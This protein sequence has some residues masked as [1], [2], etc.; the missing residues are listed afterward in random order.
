MNNQTLW[1]TTRGAGM[2][3]LILLSAVLALGV[4]AQSRFGTRSWPRFLTPAFHRNLSM[5]A[6]LF[7]LLHIVTAVTDPFTHLGF[8]A[9]VAPFGSYYRPI[10]LGL[11]TLSFELMLAVA[12]TSFIRP[13]IGSRAWKTIHF[14]SY[15]L[16]GIAVIHGLGTGSD[17]SALWM[18][19][20]TIICIAAVVG[21]AAWRL[22]SP[23][24]DPLAGDK[25]S[26]ASAFR[27]VSR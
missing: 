2:V 7:L 21:A 27:G 3:S 5:V 16:W 17:S 24:G 8:V 22:L 10:W 26:A 1:F 15:P 18:R 6:I 12:V 4:M 20:I 23:S 19:G 9:A 11:G 14:L 13:R 25:R